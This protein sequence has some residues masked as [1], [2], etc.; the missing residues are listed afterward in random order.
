M[1]Y[2]SGWTT[3]AQYVHAA[4]CSIVKFDAKKLYTGTALSTTNNNNK[5]KIDSWSMDC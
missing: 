3:P 5:K 2:Q 4:L 1:A